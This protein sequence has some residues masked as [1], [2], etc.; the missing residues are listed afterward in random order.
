MR[1]MHGLVALGAAA[2]GISGLAAAQ[3]APLVGKDGNSAE[4][5]IVTGTRA[6]DRTALDS[7]VPV[8]VISWTRLQDTGFPD[9]A[10]ALEASEPSL[11]FPHAETTPSSANTR[12]ITLR[13]LSPDET[14]VLVDGKRWHTTSIINVNF[15]VGRGSAPFDLSTIPLSAI[16]HIEVLRDGAAAQYGSD[17]IAGV[18]N[19]ILKKNSSGGFAELQSGVTE[20][21]DGAN[22][23]GG[24]NLGLP[25]GDGGHFTVSGEGD[26]AGPTNRAATDQRYG[27]VTY[28]IGDPEAITGDLAITAAYP[29]PLFDGELY[30]DFLSSRKDSSAA[31][32]FLTPGSSPLYPNGALPQVNPII[33][34]V[35][36]TVGFRGHL[37]GEV[38]FDVS[39]VFG[40]SNAD[41]SVN[42]TANLSLGAASPT[43]FYAG[44]AEYRQDVVN[45]TL[46]RPFAAL[47][48][49]GNLAGGVEYRTESYRLAAG[50]PS[51]IVGSG[52]VGFPGYNPRIPV[53]NSRDAVAAFL[54]AEIKP[55]DW[56]TLGAAGRY[57][58]Y[59]DFG[60][61]ATWKA[62][63]R[64][65]ATGWL[66]FRGSASTGFRAPSLQQEYYSSITTVANGANKA[67]VNVGTFQVG[68]PVA[69][70]LG[71]EP[72]KAEKS[73]DYSVGLVLTPTRGLSASVDFF[74]TDIDNRIALS[75][76]L[77]GAAV[78]RV[79]TAAGITNVQQVAF[80]TNAVDTR[81]QGYDITIRYDGN[82][83][84]ETQFHA[85]VG[86]EC[87]PTSV[88]AQT[89]N[90]A[91]PSTPFIG[92]HARTLLTEAQPRDKLTSEIVVDQGPLTG[93][94]SATRYGEYI[95]AP[96]LDPQK[97]S[98]KTIVDISLTGRLNDWV[99]LTGGI[100]NI[101]NVYPDPL[102]EVALAYKSFGNSFVYGE[103]SPWGVDGRSYY[104]KLRVGF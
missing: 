12:P 42:D 77:S 26:Y 4:E 53:D 82:F 45:L 41:I 48:A 94:L 23:D 36:D 96:I 37:P 43:S 98:A 85:S 91:L 101:G 19:I 72:L 40:Y 89:P 15:A 57:D 34:D 62:T 28:R 31:V 51:S 46:T 88:R 3:D 78:T 60:G 30:T 44:S 59:S 13:G 11:N 103:E 70:A 81:T 83:D 63:A 33:W 8:D 2:A 24:F 73:R 75:D 99:S 84:A 18:V 95:D 74:R 5:I 22:G 6:A 80:F 49:G 25:L 55:I 16:D 47:L 54:D 56:L 61:A 32:S 35:G 58:H 76:A 38:D 1:R 93:V 14:L 86:F 52:A 102:Q 66:A 50:D 79:L 92:V 65:E 17:A 100:L 67:L 10:R 87:A 104:V 71:A 29:V 90:A 7:S 21:G 97:F 39:N 27:R 9:L 64:A 68:D 20:A 69:R